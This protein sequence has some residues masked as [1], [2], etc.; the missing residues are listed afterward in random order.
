IVDFPKSRVGAKLLP[1]YILELTPEEELK[2]LDM[3]RERLVLQRPK[4]TGR[5]TKKDRRELDDWMEE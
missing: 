3:V 4:G 2:K 5:P 1:N